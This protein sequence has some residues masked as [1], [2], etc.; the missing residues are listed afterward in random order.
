MDRLY[1][2]IAALLAAFV[3]ALPS[4]APD[5]SAILIRHDRADDDYRANPADYPF[6]AYVGVAHGTLIAPDWIL[7][8]AHVADG[9]SP[10]SG[11][12]TIGDRKRE[13]RRI[14]YHPTWKGDL[15]EGFAEPTWIDLALI[16]L[17][18]P[19]KDIKPV[20]LYD[21][22]DELGCEVTFVG[23]GKTGDGRGGALREDRQL[24]FATNVVSKLQSHW[25][26]FSYDEP[27]NGTSLEGI[28]GP[29]DSGGPAL[30]R[31]NHEQYVIGVCFRND[32][33]G[34]PE[35]EFKYG[36]SDIYVRV[37]SNIDWIRGII[38]EGLLQPEWQLI[39][40]DGW[41]SGTIGDGAKAFFEAF[42]RIE[43]DALVDF[44]KT[45]RFENELRGLS[46]EMRANGWLQ[47]ARKWKSLVPRRWLQTTPGKVFFLAQSG[48]QWRSVRFEMQGPE[49]MRIRDI[50]ICRESPPLGEAK[51]T[52]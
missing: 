33:Q 15:P 41:P 34:N 4:S 12:I 47:Q 24:R 52:R 48:D 20:R 28:G 26:H 30:I 35:R 37:S 31:D 18:K 45:W 38:A 6:L 49:P 17:V 8:S 10:V 1:R 25:L 2:T 9:V 7:T 51:D 43:F 42:N 21:R 39:A 32:G 11:F 19:V 29:G 22:G 16:Q 44:E 5:A 46:A 27:P 36:T 23:R 14:V 3:I 13:V 40:K 50:L